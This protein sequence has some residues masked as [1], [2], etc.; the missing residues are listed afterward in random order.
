MRIAV[1]GGTG[2]TG[3]AIVQALLDHGHEVVVCEHRRAVPVAPS[4][5]L[6]R[7][8]ADV[9]DR[10]ALARA[11]AGCDAV[12]HL[13]AILREEP[14]KGVTFEKVHV[15]G[16][17]NVVEA[18]RSAG[19]RR[20]LLMSANG[21]GGPVDTP[22]YRTKAEMERLVRDAGAFA[23][24]ILRPSFIAAP[25][26]GGFDHQF[27]QVVDRFPV[28]PALGGG[29]FE[30]QPVSRRDVALAF[31][32]AADR[33]VAHGKTYTLVG[34]ERFTWR[35]YLRRLSRLRRRKRALVPAPAGA[36]AFAA[37]TMPFLLPMPVSSDQVRM[38]VA[39]NVGDASEAVR[40]LGLDLERWEN[41]VAGLARE[42]S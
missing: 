8:K 10:E 25:D 17:R 24:T 22:Y 9:G 11:F 39:G 14:R 35:D 37:R 5:R 23:W 21:V 1:T 29:R 4:P 26:E 36:V 3:P 30:I 33:P 27:A 38:L 34:P 32:R 20:F 12:A 13:V 40:D 42:P 2:F 31:A 16:T 6:H 19:V 41:A 7:A 28:L 15:E 18:A